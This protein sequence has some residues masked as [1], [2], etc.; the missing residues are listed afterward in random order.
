MHKYILYKL[1][2]F[3]FCVVVVVAFCTQSVNKT[4]ATVT[5][6]GNVQIPMDYSQT[7]VSTLECPS[8]IRAHCVPVIQTAAQTSQTEQHAAASD[9][10]SNVM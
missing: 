1:F 3:F 6:R 8:Y 10:N 2:F 5:Q 4:A 7:V 9:L